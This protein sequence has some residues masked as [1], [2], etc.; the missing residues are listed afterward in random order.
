MKVDI[1]VNP[2][3]Y[4]SFK[5]SY[6]TSYTPKESKE[7]DFLD[8]EER[9]WQSQSVQSAFTIT[10]ARK[11][12]FKQGQIHL[13]EQQ[14]T[15][16][17]NLPVSYTPFTNALATKQ[18]ATSEKAYNEAMSRVINLMDELATLAINE[19]GITSEL[20]YILADTYYGFKNRADEN[21]DRLQLLKQALKNN[22]NTNKDI[23]KAVDTYFAF[24]ALTAQRAIG[25]FDY[26]SD[27]FDGLP[28]AQIMQDLSTIKGWWD[29][30]SRECL[31]LDDGT[32]VGFTHAF[33]KD[34][35]I[36]NTTLVTSLPNGVQR[37]FNTANL[38]DENSQILFEMFKQRENL[39]GLESENLHLNS[40]ENSNLQTK[41]N[42]INSSTNSKQNLN[43]NTLNLSENLIANLNA[44]STQQS[45]I[46]TP[47][48]TNLSLQNSNHRFTMLVESEN[49]TSIINSQSANGDT[50]IG[51]WSPMIREKGAQETSR[52]LSNLINSNSK[53]AQKPSKAEFE[54]AVK[55]ISALMNELKNFVRSEQGYSQLSVDLQYL[56]P[57]DYERT[58]YE[59][60]QTSSNDSYDSLW[61]G[62]QIFF[63]FLNDK[64]SGLPKDEINAYI[65][66][67]QAYLVAT[68]LNA[69]E[70]K[71]TQNSLNFN[72][73]NLKLNS[74]DSLLKEL[75]KNV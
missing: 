63:D 51:M 12:M 24:G 65:S 46:F 52:Y 19:Q 17:I 62:A 49:V 54:R 75:L 68:K 66:T 6:K 59:S 60:M 7:F 40:S 8:T 34:G 56:A 22:Q 4:T 23:I 64:V 28:T 70:L 26:I 57:D 53:V 47:N 42:L 18:P 58:L 32:K 15:A 55:N 69:N 33:D 38:D 39:N 41:F 30:N 3:N 14:L 11:E 37:K 25:L 16:L 9:A 10:A 50:I 61:M 29:N 1:Y 72:S 13:N 2:L 20:G 5:G 27:K 44:N 73:E 71:L 45:E 48:S 31:K 67:I 21:Y 74:N 35:N 36:T 43:F